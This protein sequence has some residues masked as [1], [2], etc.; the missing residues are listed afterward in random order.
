MEYPFGV[1]PTSS[2]WSTFWGFGVSATSLSAWSSF[3]VS[4][5]SLSARATFG[6]SLTSCL[7]LTSQG[8]TRYDQERKKIAKKLPKDADFAAAMQLGNFSVFLRPQAVKNT[9]MT[10]ICI[11]IIWGL[12]SLII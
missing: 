2:A 10:V 12:P 8:K 5:T 7:N 9:A 4:P 1:S 3:G 6:V 11:V